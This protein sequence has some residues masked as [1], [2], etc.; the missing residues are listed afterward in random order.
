LALFAQVCHQGA[1]FHVGF[2]IY[3]EKD[4]FI[5]NIILFSGQKKSFPM[6]GKT[7]RAQVISMNPII[8][9]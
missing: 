8:N 7:L 4:R 5:T 6:L 2:L 1:M 9:Q 3:N